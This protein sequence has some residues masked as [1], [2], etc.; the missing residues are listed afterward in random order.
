MNTKKYTSIIIFIFLLLLFQNV[1][2]CTEINGILKDNVVRYDDCDA[3]MLQIHSNNLFVAAD[4]GVEIFEITSNTTLEHR[5]TINSDLYCRT[6]HVDDNGVLIVKDEGVYINFYYHPSNVSEMTSLGQVQA[7]GGV[8]RDFFVHENL[9]YV[10]NTIGGL[11]IY[12]ITDY[13]APERLSSIDVGDTVDCV[14]VENSTAY[15]A[16]YYFPSGYRGFATINVTDP[17][18]PEIEDYD[19]TSFSGI[20]M[21]KIYV[22][23]GNIYVVAH[24]GLYR[25]YIDGS[26][27]SYLKIL[28]FYYAY[29][30]E[31]RNNIMY[32]SEGGAITEINITNPS[33]SHKIGETFVDAEGWDLALYGNQTFIADGNKGFIRCGVP[34]IKTTSVTFPVYYFFPICFTSVSIMLIYLQKRKRR[35]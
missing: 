5:R 10:A 11:V 26:D 14:Y 19:D 28:P 22:N 29:N 20:W 17:T 1:I 32:V 7:A 6:I 16:G 31:I 13:S 30:Y 18:A 24:D 34:D 27:F 15:V 9:L 4:S 23:D 3:Y 33:A 2:N 12:N 8:I 25:V 21:K 35:F